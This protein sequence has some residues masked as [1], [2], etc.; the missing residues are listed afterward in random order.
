MRRFNALCASFVVAL[1]L[2]GVAA[3]GASAAKV[4]EIKE[5]GVPL[6]KGSRIVGGMFVDGCFAFGEG[7]LIN[8]GAS[9][10]LAEFP[11]AEGPFNCGLVSRVSGRIGSVT[12]AASGAGE[13]KPNLSVTLEGRLCVYRLTKLFTL[14]FSVPGE[15]EASGTEPGKLN[16]AA[17]EASC[18]RSES[19]PL[20]VDLTNEENG[21][22]FEL[23]ARA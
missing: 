6:A 5:G 22:P 10:D 15:T 18:A 19:I 13:I 23:E 4:L 2:T 9:K 14:H 11:G 16:K 1:A 3:A 12:I 7:T 21:T 17:S 8:N 20:E